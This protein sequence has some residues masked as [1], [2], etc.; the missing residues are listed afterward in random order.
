MRN[1][2]F[3]I[4]L[5]CLFTSC[6]NY[7][8]PAITGHFGIEL[9]IIGF[10]CIAVGFAIGIFWPR[11][12]KYTHHKRRP[13]DNGR[14]TDNDLSDVNPLRL[15]LQQQEDIVFNLETKLK[16]C[17]SEKNTIRRLLDEAERLSAIE[18]QERDIYH[19]NEG[20][21]SKTAKPESINATTIYYLKPSKDGM[22]REPSKVNKMMDALY[23]LTYQN[24]NPSEATVAFV[25]SADNVFGALQNEATWLLAVCERSNFPTPQTKS[26]RTDEPGRAVFKNGEWEVVQKAKITYI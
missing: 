8:A 6:G 13:S 21:N 3:L 19:L 17:E 23:A 25:D 14:Q 10:F 1:L 5:L 26:I 20:R 18:I 7:D 12:K 22:F 11:K 9:P 2:L 16:D 4:F 24:E 15:R